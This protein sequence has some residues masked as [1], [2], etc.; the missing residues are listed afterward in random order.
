MR[1][2]P[3]SPRTVQPRPPITRFIETLGAMW[4]RNGLPP[5]A[6]RIFGLLLVAGR[7]L[8]GADLAGALQISRSS[9]STDVRGLLALGVVDRT[10]VPG[11]RAGYY[12]F[13][14]H[15][16]E[17]VLASR[18]AEARRYR[19]LAEQTLRELAAGH[20]GRKHL[21]ELRE[22]AEIFIRAL[23]RMRA[24]WASRRGRVGAGRR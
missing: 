13:S 16:W 3:R 8:T 19:D 1:S 17:H 12:V 21:E 5:G 11:H 23:D 14:P 7:P 20:P 18:G 22:W 10:R 4:E 6:G 24:E 15:A 9:V 2:Y